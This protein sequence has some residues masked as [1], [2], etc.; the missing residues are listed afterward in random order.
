[1]RMQVEQG[2]LPVA[3]APLPDE[4]L[5]SWC[6]RY[7]RL[8]ANGLDKNTSVQLFG[9]AR[10]GLA[11]DFPC[12]LAAL[13]ERSCGILGPAEVIM[14]CMTLLPFYLPF[15]CKALGDVAEAALLGDGISHLKYRLGLLTSGL[16]A[17][18]PLKACP[19]CVA[20]DLSTY[21]WAYWRRNHQLPSVW[22]C[23]EHQLGL[24]VY[25]PRAKQ[26]FR[27]AWTLPVAD[28]YASL[29][30]LDQFQL[31][32]QE[33]KW[34]SK[35]G[36]LST[37]LVR[38]ET[39]Q[40]A[41]A[42]RV[43]EVVRCRLSALDLVHRGRLRWSKIRLHLDD[44]A[45]WLVKLPGINHE[46][47]SDL[48]AGQL[49]RVLS[50]RA[51]SHPLRN[52]VWI[53]L[54]FED[55]ADFQNE[56]DSAGKWTTLGDESPPKFP[57]QLEP[58]SKYAELLTSVA[59]RNI[60]MTSAA[61]SAGVSYSTMAAWA[62][63]LHIPSPRR[64]KKLLDREWDTAVSMLLAG[65]SKAE[66]AKACR[67]SIVTVT[68]IIRTVPGLQDKW[69]EVLHDQRREAAR[70]SWSYIAHL[71]SYIGI[72]A[73]R[74]LEPASYAWLYRND[75][76]WLRQ[77]CNSVSKERGSNFA[78]K[79]IANADM[80]MAAALQ[81]A[82]ENWLPSSRARSLD[83]ISRSLPGIRKA[84]ENPGQW[85]STVKTLSSVLSYEPTSPHQKPLLC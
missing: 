4:T 17:A 45:A 55:L 38:Y 53:S 23:A 74:K 15:K 60:S 32:A 2:G 3:L 47:S 84:I 21:G 52:L 64:P 68:R 73:L 61:R 27:S 79:R 51:L 83:E 13:A 26:L 5:F 20:N 6:S 44:L 82:A 48:L 49:Q 40:F 14:Q 80:R 54:W 63:K 59:T 75:R 56:Y 8:T 50:G 71:R 25:P 30:V 28:E 36:Q 34:L 33:T 70:Q 41:D 85:P 11:H 12:R 31:A 76:E 24:T 7:H 78:S 65:S 10:A 69:H 46:A 58:Q 37:D 72:A 16:G 9:D 19:A 81:V 77:S 1:M 42:E 43:A 66:V 39:G 29:K 22:I 67:S 18:H 57:V 35:L 62:S